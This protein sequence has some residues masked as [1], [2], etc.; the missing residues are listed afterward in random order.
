M[1]V[2][3]LQT[4][5][6]W[7]QPE[8]NAQHAERL[9]NECKGSDLYVL[10]EM[11]ST[12]FATNPDGIAET[13]SQSLKWMQKMAEKK[14]AAI[15]G[16]LAIKDA[17]GS[18]RNRHYFVKPDGSYQ[19]YDKRHLF[20]YGGEDKNY[21][22]GEERTVVEYGGWRFLLLT[23]YDLRFPVWSRYRGDYDA[24]IYVS[25][26]PETRQRVWEILL[27]A[28]A[29]ENQ[30]Y[31]IAVNRVGNDDQCSYVGGSCIIDAKGTTIIESVS[32]TEQEL[33]AELSKEKLELFRNKFQVL[34]DRD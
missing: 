5:I 31:V 11:W 30:C 15:C 14:Q 6:V 34:K 3:I 19:F 33:T 8:R 16:S 26:W 12:G 4:D 20:S 13:D 18:Y 10:P 23:C 9:I 17:D 32:P 2:S 1:I 25:N 7:A 28:R 29:I 24:I 27:R 21:T 22:R